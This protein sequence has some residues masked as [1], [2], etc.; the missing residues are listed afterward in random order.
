MQHPTITDY[1]LMK[2]E[3]KLQSLLT[4]QT[5]ET[6][7]NQELLLDSAKAYAYGYVHATEGIAVISDFHKNTCHIY[8]GKFGKELLELPNYCT[9]DDSAFETGIFNCILKEDLLERHILELRFLAYLKDIPAEKKTE[10]QASCLI[11][12]KKQDDKTLQ[13]LHTTR[14]LNCLPNGSVQL[15]LCTYIPFFQTDERLEGGINNIITGEAIC[16]EQYMQ[17]DN[18]LLSKRQTE[19]LALAA[20]G[21][22]SKQIADKLSISLH[23]V[24]RH[25]QDILSA[26]HVTN[27]AAAVKIGLHLHLI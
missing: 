26:L 21:I 20:K 24:N 16:P 22:S 3:N 10:Y 14:Y 11:R 5:F 19:I 13:I 7:E 1:T 2:Q 15:G 23:T 4:E 8:S 12:C 9:D 6:L 27:T 25:R 18:R 17:C